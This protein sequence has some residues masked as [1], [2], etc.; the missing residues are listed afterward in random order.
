MHTAGSSPSAQEIWK[1]TFTKDAI[2]PCFVRDVFSM[3]EPSGKG[4]SMAS[5]TLHSNLFSVSE[6]DFFWLGTTPC[7][8]VLI[9]AMIVAVQIY[10]KR[11]M[12][13]SN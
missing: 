8:S 12:Y 11:T 4:L 3:R 13:T 10:E 2:A 9:V 6:F 1:W 7:R 5:D